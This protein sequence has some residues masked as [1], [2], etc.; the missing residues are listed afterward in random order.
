METKPNFFEKY[1][2]FFIG[3][4][5]ILLCLIVALW[6]FNQKEINK[7]YTAQQAAASLTIQPTATPELI[8][9]PTPVITDEQTLK[10]EN[11]G[12]SDETEEIEKDLKATDL[13]NLDKEVIT[14]EQ[15]LDKR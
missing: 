11:Q 8:I 10:L 6:L 1:W 14:I 3:L 12:S 13:T 5:I 2:Y 7:Q 9:T 4:A 15:E